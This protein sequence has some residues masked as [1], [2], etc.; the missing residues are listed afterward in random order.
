MVLRTTF[1]VC[2][3]KFWEIGFFLENFLTLFSNSGTKQKL[4]SLLTIFFSRFSKMHF[5]CREGHSEKKI[6][7]KVLLFIS[8]GHWARKYWLLTIVLQRDSQKLFIRV[9]KSTFRKF[10]GIIVFLG[11]FRILNENNSALCQ[12]FFKRVLETAVSWFFD[13]KQKVLRTLARTY[14]TCCWNVILR[15]EQQFEKTVFWKNKDFLNLEI[16]W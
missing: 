8:F 12:T 2:T 6:R 14:K 13:I 7:W 15:V 9:K 16:F 3:G 5:S 4:F 10:V 1:Y 11:T